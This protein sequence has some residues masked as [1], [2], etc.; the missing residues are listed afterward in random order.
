MKAFQFTTVLF[1]F[2]LL[3]LQCSASSSTKSEEPDYTSFGEPVPSDYDSTRLSAELPVQIATLEKYLKQQS[4]KY[5]PNIAFFIDMRI[6]SR[7]YRFFVVDLT[8]DSIIDRALVAH[9]SGS[10]T[11]KADS[12]QFSNI[13]N[14]YMSSLGTYKVG[15]SYQGSFGRSFKL[16]GLDPTNSKA[17]ERYV[18]LHRYSCVPDEEQS[19]PICNSLG[20]PMVSEAFFPKLEQYIDSQAK[21]ILLE[22]YY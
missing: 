14:S 9:G 19:Y 2:S 17:L 7:Y 18:V 13:P 16:N 20:C 10:E 21:P 11:E 22:I 8:K 1:L 12:L 6:P 5:S 4:G 3:I 15:A